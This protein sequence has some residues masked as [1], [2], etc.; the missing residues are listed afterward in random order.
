MFCGQRFGKIYVL[1][2]GNRPRQHTKLRLGSMSG[3]RWEMFDSGH[4]VL[5]CSVFRT[6][7]V[8]ILR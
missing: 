3:R 8:V 5:N 4:D 1:M 6:R 2:I 7:E